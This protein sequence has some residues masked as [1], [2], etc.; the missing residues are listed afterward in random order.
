[1]GGARLGVRVLI[2]ASTRQTRAYECSQIG[3]FLFPPDPLML[4]NQLSEI[5]DVSRTRF[6]YTAS[7]VQAYSILTPSGHIDGSLGTHPALAGRMSATRPR[8]LKNEGTSR[9]RLR[10]T[11]HLR[12][13]AGNR[14]HAQ[15][16]DN[17]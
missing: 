9:S 7:A 13:Q 8:S 5:G 11:S 2:G 16:K 4:H 15:D 14:Y 10:A 3:S 17:R 12:T 6:E 1:M